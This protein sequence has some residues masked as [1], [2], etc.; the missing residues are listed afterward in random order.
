[1]KTTLGN[2]ASYEIIQSFVLNKTRLEFPEEDVQID[3]VPHS[4]KY[5]FRIQHWPFKNHRNRLEICIDQ[6][7]SEAVV[8]SITDTTQGGKIHIST[9]Y[10]V[11]TL[12]TI[13]H[14]FLK[15]AT[16]D[17]KSTPIEIEEVEVGQT[18]L[19]V[20]SFHVSMFYDPNF[21]LLLGGGGGGGINPCAKSDLTWTYI[22]SGFLIGVVIL[23]G[24]VILAEWHIDA[25]RKL[26]RGKSGYQNMVFRRKKN[27]MMKEKSKRFKQ[28]PSKPN[29]LI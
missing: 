21:G 18:I 23:S 26:I 12:D 19:T 11:N 10:L 13:Q 3:L 24:L 2:G 29:N 27:Q 17:G 15:F 20:P 5:S 4:V 6:V 1:M 16:L 14:S 8:C 28:N 25:F 9:G 7:A 22:S